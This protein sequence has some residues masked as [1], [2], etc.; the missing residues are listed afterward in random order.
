MAVSDRA[1][2]FIGLGKIGY[3]MA[4]HLYASGGR[5]T[6]YDL[7]PEQTRRFATEYSGSIA[8]AGLAAFSEAAVVLTSLPDSTAVDSVIRGTAT[9][10]G[11]IDILAAGS[12]VIDL[13]SAEPMRSRA[14]ARELGER[15]LHFLDAPV[16]GGV[17][18][19]LDG[20]LTI[21][22]GG[23]AVRY[24][25][26]RDLLHQIGST[27][28][29]VGAAGAGH[30]LKA[31]NNYVSA[32]GLVATV[33]AVLVGQAFGLDAEVMIDVL[34]NSTGKNYTTENKV[35]QFMLSS[36][37]N[38]GFSLGLMAKDIKTAVQLG[39]ALGWRMRLGHAVVGVWSDAAEDLPPMAD[40][41]EMHR[42]LQAI[43]K[44][45]PA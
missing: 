32:A 12:A 42:Y 35:K 43:E 21:M 40:H 19:A 4:A 18:R 29:Y 45:L 38:S 6:V 7:V 41:T 22:V 30:A 3:P 11:L 1:T 10:T 8:A 2:G 39:E 13:S 36:A 25:E 31:L 28:T 9:E 24:E 17:T 37:F 26:H 23:D 44:T 16:S 33:E 34:N 15:G 5:L 14:L 27:V 20:S